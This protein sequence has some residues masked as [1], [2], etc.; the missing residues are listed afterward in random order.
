M[1]NNKMIVAYSRLSEEDL[2]KK[3]EYSVSIYNQL[4]LIKDY[5]NRMELSIDKEYIDDGYSGINFDRPGFEKMISD[6]ETGKI[7]TVI[8][9]DMSRLGREFIDTAYYISEFFPKHDIRYIA[10]NDQYDSNSPDSITKE[11]MVNIRAI[12]NDRYVKDTSLKRMQTA[13]AKTENGEFI[14]FVAPYGYRV[15]KKEG[16]RTLEI[17]EYASIIV[18]RIFTSVASGKT[19]NEVAEELNNDK[20]LPPVIYMNMTPSRNK[21]YY[22]DWSSRVIYRILKNKTYTGSMVVRKSIKKNY[23]QN[24][25]TFIPMGDR[26]IKENTHPAIITMELYEAANSRL[27]NMKRK[28]KNCYDGTLSGLVFCGV[29]SRVMT[30]CRRRRENGN[31][32]YYFACAK[33]ENRKKCP[34]R[35]ISDAKLRRIIESTLK[36]LINDFVDGE[37]IIND[38]SKKM[39]KKDR[40]DLK[41]ANIKQDIEVRDTNIRNLYLKKTRGEL[42]LEEFIKEKNKEAKLKSLQ[43]EN[44]RMLV[45]KRN[46]DYKRN[47]VIG[48]YNQFINDGIFLKDYVKYFIDKIIIHKDN[49]IQI[50]FNF[51]VGKTKTIKLY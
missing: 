37:E 29:C 3:R 36:E 12:V 1:S 13:I 49:T 5:A 4:S 43:E 28:E 44:L 9:K 10:I 33:V 48:L 32:E 18:K 39:I 22:Y 27:R 47:E 34:N 25:R 35:I 11:I 38:V 24:K 15:V 26:K 31:V 45:E 46:S 41:I 23:K 14:G 19:R 50:V 20:V 8:T 2:E 21:K 30:A 42:I 6:I 16:K 40:I 51:G 17:D 7:S